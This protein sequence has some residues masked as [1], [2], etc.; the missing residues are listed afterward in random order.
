MPTVQAQS[1]YRMWPVEGLPLRVEFSMPVLEEVSASAVDGL[2]RFRHGGV[3]VGGVLYGTVTREAVRIS[4]YRPLEC[5]HAF[6][7]RFVLSER[8]RAEMKRLIEAPGHEAG[9][10][11][12]T[13][14]GWYHS[15][16]RSEIS[17]SP[18]DLEIHDR[19]FTQPT[20]VALIVRPEN[21]ESCRAGFF[22]REF[23]GRLRTDASFHEFSMRPRRHGLVAAKPGAEPEAPPAPAAAPA[24]APVPEAA[25][26]APPRPAP[27]PEPEG[28]PETYTLPSFVEVERTR[29]YRWL[30][31]V[32]GLVFALL[33]GYVYHTYYGFTDTRP[34]LNLWVA[35]IGG[36]LLIDWDR[37]AAPVRNARS[38]RIEIQDGAERETVIIPKDRLREGSVDYVRRGDVLDIRLVLE[39]SDGRRV[40]E[41]IRFVGQPVNRPPTTEMTETI[42][43]RDELKAEVEKLRT[44]LQRRG[45]R[46]RT[47]RAATPEGAKPAARNP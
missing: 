18:R 38:G 30:W 37:T 1:E 9:L 6:G 19:F 8:D 24:A 26:A 10:K 22:V 16:T 7:P 20:H 3:E 4:A 42:R 27:P 14:V 15:H 36:Q 45:A 47:P 25:A 28:E 33:G 41:V 17:L 46:R 21:Y 39:Q 29:N 13:P 35:D 43:E 32:A 31:L 2:Y 11:G 40:Q 44:E 34:E 5:E 12:L 23:N